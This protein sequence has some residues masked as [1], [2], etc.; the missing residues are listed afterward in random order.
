MHRSTRRFSVVAV[1][2]GIGI[3]TTSMRSLPW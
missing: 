1:L 3:A 2:A